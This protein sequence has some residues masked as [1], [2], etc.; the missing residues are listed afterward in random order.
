MNDGQH[1]LNATRG[2]CSTFV[3]SGSRHYRVLCGTAIPQV[4]RYFHSTI[5]QIFI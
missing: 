1:E 4:P 5:F 3:S 2:Y